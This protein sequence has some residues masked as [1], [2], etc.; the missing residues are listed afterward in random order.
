MTGQL[1]EL[2]DLEERFCKDIQELKIL[3]GQ[4]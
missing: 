4:I 3:T 1:H 2:G